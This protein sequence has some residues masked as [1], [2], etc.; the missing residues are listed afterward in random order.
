LMSEI[1]ILLRPV[2]VRSKIGKKTTSYGASASLFCGVEWREF[3]RESAG[4]VELTRESSGGS[5]PVLWSQRERIRE[6]VGR[7]C[8]FDGREFTD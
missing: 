3:R 2:E 8:G 5:R 6:G 4:S 7:F 1:S